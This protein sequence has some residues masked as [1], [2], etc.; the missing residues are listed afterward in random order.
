MAALTLL[1]AASSL[2]VYVFWKVFTATRSQRIPTGLKKL[3]GPKGMN[4][5]SFMICL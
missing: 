4:N 2:L 3:P 1:L 5:Y